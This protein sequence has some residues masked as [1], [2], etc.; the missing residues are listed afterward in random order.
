MAATLYA[1]Y[2]KNQKQKET[3]ALFEENTP[4]WLRKIFV[5]E[6]EKPSV[7]KD[8]SGSRLIYTIGSNHDR[9]LC[10]P[11]VQVAYQHMKKNGD[12]GV[13]RWLPSSHHPR[14]AA[15]TKAP[16]MSGQDWTFLS[17]MMHT[18]GDLLRP[19]EG[20]MGYTALM[21]LIKSKRFF[22]ESALDLPFSLGPKGQLDFFWE[23]FGD[24]YRLQCKLDAIGPMVELTLLNLEPIC[25]LD[26]H[27]KRIGICETPF[28]RK[29]L[30]RLLTLPSLSRTQAAEFSS[31]IANH[32]HLEGLPLPP[33]R[34]LKVKIITE[35]P[36]AT[37]KLEGTLASHMSPAFPIGTIGFQYGKK[38]I[39]PV[40]FT[41]STVEYHVDDTKYVHT[42][43]LSW[44]KNQ[45]ALLEKVGL[46]PLSDQ[47]TYFFNLTPSEFKK[48]EQAFI[49]DLGKP[50]GDAQGIHPS[51]MFLE[52]WHAFLEAHREDLKE[53][54][55]IIET[56]STFPLVDVDKDQEWYSEI[57]ESG[58]NWF[59]LDMGVM[60]DGKKVNLLPILV[61]MLHQ[62]PDL[63][64][65]QSQEMETI[66]IEN[67]DGRCFG[68][69]LERLM[70]IL[71]L[72]HQLTHAELRPNN[73]LRLDS[74]DMIEFL[75]QQEKENLQIQALRSKNLAHLHAWAKKLRGL[76]EVPTITAPK[77][78]QA[79]LRP[80]QQEG[81]NWMQYLA[82]N[83]LPGILADDM[84]LGKTIQT[85]AH[86]LQE[87]ES[88]RL[89]KPV[90]IV[91]PT[92]L[93]PNWRSELARFSPTLKT[94]ILHGSERHGKVK[95]IPHV[96]VVC[97]TYPL[98]SRDHAELLKHDFHT[99]VLDEAQFIKN[100]KTQ[101]NKA[102]CSLKS[103]RRLCLT[104]TPLENHLGEVWSIFNFLSPGLLG[105]E[106]QFKRS[107]RTPIEKHGDMER[108]KVLNRRLRLFM[109]RRTKDAVLLDLPPKTEII[110]R[111]EF[112]QKQRDLYEA[113]R[114]LMHE[115]VQGELRKH[116]EKYNS[117]VI[118]DALLKLRQIC[119]D[120]SLLKIPEA[121]GIASAKLDQL[122]E[123]IPE[124]VEEGRKILL[125]SQFTSMLATIEKHLAKMA[126][127]YVKI[128]GQTKD[129]ETPIQAFQKG[130]VP[131]FLISLK[132]GG[133]GLNLT[134]AD[135]VIHF[136]PWWNPAAENQATDRAH[137]IG[138]TKP[139]FV[140]KLIAAQSVEEKILEMQVKKAELAKA[141]FEDTVQG[142]VKLS[143]EDITNLFDPV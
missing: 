16:Y 98:I 75:N 17:T 97:T 138:Q 127:P 140:Y 119:C 86:L 87:K 5:E 79:T 12:Y 61:K 88:G 45:M 132:A 113:T 99:I 77:G 67:S 65:L 22:L 33:L 133:T 125:F 47:M 46:I 106:D 64:A 37:L 90:L 34:D 84:G 109:M 121:Q 83:Q 1:H 53:A 89:D 102:L 111:S 69:P 85:I 4:D 56:T 10:S 141:L 35:K 38:V 105:A 7:F 116:G 21:E 101:T 36:A 110:V 120:P 124:M 39:N 11:P 139:I 107:F 27:R 136:D 9:G 41:D 131:L 118:L 43:D 80:Y 100:S 63:D 58:N 48:L 130:D 55:W 74:L 15:A 29:M 96:D 117:I 122:M 82:Q 57:D 51:R 49:P 70:P 92:S 71:R 108:Q 59:D 60:V 126:I 3:S 137:R 6:N 93:M 23:R 26:S 142:P 30:H 129:R 72:V 134:A 76:V 50:I 103:N 62:I 104:G 40:T 28:P 18:Y 24:T 32:P 2:D 128:T 94:L 42:R 143:P 25:Y 114:L 91:G 78:L 19:L 73:R 95:D 115:K 66:Y 44:E 135:T 31:Y 81:L 52:P 123:M 20:A 112:D 54:G 14:Y 13:P 68:F 8:A